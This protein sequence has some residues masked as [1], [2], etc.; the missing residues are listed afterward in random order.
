MCRYF[1][2]LLESSPRN[3]IEDNACAFPVGDLLNASAEF[4]IVSRNHMIRTEVEERFL[5]YRWARCRDR[6][7]ADGPGDL[8]RC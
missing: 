7:H 4:F 8:S 5:V 6:G 1:G 2:E 3:E